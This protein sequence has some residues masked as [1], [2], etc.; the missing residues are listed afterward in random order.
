MSFTAPHPGSQEMP[1]WTT[2]ELVEPPKLG[3]NLWA[4][5][6]PGI[7]MSASAIGGGEWLLGPTVTARYGGSLLWLA[8]LSIV[9][10]ALYN[11]EISRY[12][13]YCGEPIFCGK[14][15]TLPGPMFWVFVYLLF[16]F[17]TV[18]PYLAASAATP[19]QVIL[20][21]GEIPQPDTN[22]AHWWLAK[23]TAS[24]IF[25]LG[26]IPLVVGG[27]IFNSLRVL[28]A[29][30]LVLVFGFLLVLAVFYSHWST[31]TEI[32]SGFFQFG[33]VPVQHGEDWNGNGRLD[34]GE[35]WDRDG[36][37]DVVEESLPG[38]AFRD[39]D[40]DGIQDGDNVQNVFSSL[41]AGQFP[42]IDF[43][44]VALITAMAAIAGNGGLSNTPMS[45][46]IRDQGWGMGHHVGAIPSFIGGR[47][48]GLSHVGC[49]F[50]VNEH[51][52]PRWRRWYRKV[53]REQLLVWM[54]A[55]FVGLAL[56]SML[57][58]EFL[59]RG[60]RTDE[61]NAAVMTASGVR[62]HV[63]NPSP[64][65]LAY[66]AG[67][68]RVLYGQAWGR[69]FWSLTL[70]CGFLVLAATLVSN[71]DGIIRRWVDVFWTSSRNL[72]EVHPESIRH[73]YFGVLLAYVAFGLVALWL[74]KPA[75]LIKWATLGFNLALGFSCW[76]TL[77]INTLLLP[78]DLRPNL[79]MRAALLLGGL[80]FACLF[81]V[82]LL[83]QLGAFS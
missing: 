24:G 47:G 54:P 74:N 83:N 44:L 36:R 53:L 7:V 25:L 75:E 57:S 38:G 55:C 39:I 67:L 40:G 56:P 65:V 6:G 78:R 80:F 29:T 23:G 19:L 31:W 17:S 26:M 22:R 48:I 11:V 28:M 9:F 72:R 33:N 61:W 52:L 73:V 43:G 81:L 2:G 18:F 79:F 77:A 71:T 51:S 46:Y 63:A 50:E 1:R 68:A 20:L 60:T 82:T 14:F 12:T 10:Q 76:H 58:V 49:V 8:T 66:E 69:L 34:P 64:G 15:R 41:A 70:F 21:G 27:K 42:Q 32:G 5:V 3:W 35:D 62:D 16:D 37:L 13:L 30:K 59:P 45:N 4:L